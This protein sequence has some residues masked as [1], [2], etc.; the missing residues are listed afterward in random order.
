MESI[1][2]ALVAILIVNGAG[3]CIL[4]WVLLSI[5]LEIREIKNILI[6]TNL[7]TKRLGIRIDR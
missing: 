5:E 3:L 4:I 6:D 1:Y 7:D 2:W